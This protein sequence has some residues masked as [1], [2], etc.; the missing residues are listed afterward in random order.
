MLYGVLISV[1]LILLYKFLP[2]K[3]IFPYLCV[4]LAIVFSVSAFI[5]NRHSQE[6]LTRAQI[7]ELQNRQKIFGE[8]YAEYQKNINR[9]DL[10][11]QRYFSIVNELKTAEIYEYT[12]Y[13]QL[14]DLEKESAEEKNRIDELK[15]PPEL[16]ELSVRLLESVIEK[17]KAYA[18]A[19][20]KTISLTR[21]AADPEIVTNINEMN[22][23]IKEINIR[24]SPTGL[25]TASEI[26]AIREI[27]RDRD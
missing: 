21:Q 26:S 4:A 3:K 2:N 10:N 27:L 25:F 7:E 18:T 5:Q 9:L 24:E 11:W 16:D 19:Q 20:A 13:E 23:R 15:V 17:T 12:M 8:W 1:A 6:I 14:L 22:K